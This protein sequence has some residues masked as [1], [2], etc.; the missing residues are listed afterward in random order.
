M[1]TAD[2]KD[3]CCQPAADSLVKVPVASALPVESHSV[4]VWMPALVEPL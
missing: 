4:A 1:A 3:S 2:G